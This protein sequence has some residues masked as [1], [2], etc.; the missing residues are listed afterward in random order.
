[1]CIQLGVIA[2]LNAREPGITS[3]DFGFCYNSV[4]R[5]VSL[6]LGDP[7]VPFLVGFMTGLKGN[8]T[9]L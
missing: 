1:M 2:P 5:V 9:G 8:D 3:Q 6:P 4:S 7:P